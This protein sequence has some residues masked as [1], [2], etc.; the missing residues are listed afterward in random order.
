MDRL[1]HAIKNVHRLDDLAA[2]DTFL[3]RLDPTAKLLAVLVYLAVTLSF[4]RY[5]LTGL[6]GMGLF[7][8]LLYEIDDLSLIST[9]RQARPV[10]VLLAAVGVFNLF[11]DR[12]P[13]LTLGPLVLSGGWVSLLTLVVKGVF[14]F[15]A[16]YLLIATTGMERI[17]DALRRLHVPRVLVTTILL[18][19]RYIILLLQE[20]NRISTAY[21]LRA[22]GQRGIAF[23]A[24]GSL[25][26]QLLL[27]SIDRARVVYESMLLR[28]YGY[29]ERGAEGSATR[30]PEDW[31]PYESDAHCRAASPL[32]AAGT[33]ISLAF[34]IA[35]ILYCLI[36]RTIPVFELI[37]RLF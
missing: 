26:G 33:P 2:R 21:A 14:C 24:W 19:Y 31:P 5:A 11:F 16:V 8:I 10:V 13:R 34:L 6:L 9:L 29:A 18:T 23:K 3:T 22:P 15:L 30:R 4:D 27:R 17:C 35:T 32:A 36:F 20:A 1:H 25:L 28:G 7:P 37:G 12:T